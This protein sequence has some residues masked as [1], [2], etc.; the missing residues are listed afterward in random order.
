MKL[1]EHTD[2]QQGGADLDVDHVTRRFGEVVAVGDASFS[3][4][5]GEIVAILGPSGSGKSTML[6]MVGGQLRPDSGDIRIGGRSVVG[7]PPN[8][9][10]TATVFQDYA[11]F[12]HLTVGENVAFGLRMHRWPKDRMAAQVRHML[13]L[14]G[15][16]G[17]ETRRI[18]QLSG[19]QRQRVATA[20]ALAVE[21]KVLLLDEP[22]GALDRQIRHRLQRE[23]SQLLRQLSMTT[24]LV[25]HDQQEAY[26]MADRIAVMHRGRL[27]QIGPPGELYESPGSEFVAT[28][29]GEG[30]LLDAQLV[31]TDGDLLLVSCAGVKFTCRGRPQAGRQLRVL[32]RPEQLELI[33]PGDTGATWRGLKVLETVPLGDSTSIV[34]GAEGLELAVTALGRG[35]FSPGDIV[36][37]RVDRGG[38]VVVPG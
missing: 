8:R 22:L 20:R 5:H 34:V 12:P 29:L 35:R 7:L 33:A 1:G 3:I 37:C 11:L 24:L 21:P 25:T 13:D 27:E 32:I 9:I 31:G 17:Y 30:T 14:V 6:S 16:T 19:G 4:G 2:R 23:L 28:F 18:T 15:L 38:P 10:A 26:A 36:D